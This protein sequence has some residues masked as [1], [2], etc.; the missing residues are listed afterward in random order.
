MSRGKIPIMDDHEK[1]RQICRM[2]LELEG[3]EIFSAENGRE[4]QG[5]I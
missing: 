1:N 5:K 4:G 2:N 3:F